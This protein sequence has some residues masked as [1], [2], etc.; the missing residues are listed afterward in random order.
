MASEP[1]WNDTYLKIVDALKSIR[2]SA[3]TDYWYDVAHVYMIPPEEPDRA[4]LPFLFVSPDPE[5]GVQVQVG[6]SQTVEALIGFVVSACLKNDRGDK[7][8][9]FIDM[10]RMVA[11][12]HRALAAQTWNNRVQT[13]T[14]PGGPRYDPEHLTDDLLQFDYPVV[15]TCSFDWN[16][17]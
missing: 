4:R 6:G 13:P 12:I 5:V 2:K 16:N 11:D 1:V 14:F 17:P 3:N 7:V 8:A 15:F 9:P 10:G